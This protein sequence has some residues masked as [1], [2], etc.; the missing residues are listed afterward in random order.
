MSPQWNTRRPEGAGE[1]KDT[2]TRLHRIPSNTLCL[3]PSLRPL[4]DLVEYSQ[5]A[6]DHNR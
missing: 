3:R 5:V 1:P 4:H 2:I 6:V